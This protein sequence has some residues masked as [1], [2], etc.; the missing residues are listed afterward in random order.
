MRRSFPALMSLSLLSACAT[1][2]ELQA[3]VYRAD[4]VN[5]AQAAEVVEILAILP[6]KV[7]V[8]NTKG[9]QT[10]QLIGGVLGAIGGLALA[11]NV[12]HHSVGGNLFGG[13]AGGGLGVAAG[14]MVSDRVLV[15][16]VSLTYLRNGQTLNSAQVGKLCQY[17]PGRAIVIS[18]GPM[19][20]R[21]Q[22]NAAC[23]ASS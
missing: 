3:N 23:P 21:V 16:G 10:A 17:H 2:A 7:E 20:T 19:E 13:A 6:A 14:S 4:Q 1:G 12:G 22:P 18:T 8:D 5:Q 15:E 11:N 9:K